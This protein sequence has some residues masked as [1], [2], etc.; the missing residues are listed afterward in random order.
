ML[1]S[2]KDNQYKGVPWQKAVSK[3]VPDSQKD[4]LLKYEGKAKETLLG[5]SGISLK[6]LWEKNIDSQKFILFPPKNSKSELQ[7]DDCIFSLVNETSEAPSFRTGNIMGF[8]HL[9]D[10]QMHITSRFD[11]GP[12]NFF[13]HY[14]LQKIGNVAFTPKTNSYE[15]NILDFLCYLF[16]NYLNNALKQ[17][18]FRAYVTK[19]YNDANVRGPIDVNRHIRFNTPFN[20]KIAYRTRE[21]T[22]DNHITQLIRH[23][24]EYIRALSFGK[25]ILGGDLP[26]ETRNNVRAI[27]QA[28]ETYVKNARRQVISKNLR[29][30]THPYYT[31]YEELRKLCLA[32]LLHKRLSYG[33]SPD[34]PISGILF[35]GASLWEEYLAKII[36]KTKLGIIHSNNRKKENGICLFKNGGVYYPDFYR[37]N[38]GDK[39]DGV[40]LDAKYKALAVLS[41]AGPAETFE[42]DSSGFKPNIDRSDLFQMLAYIHCIPVSKA[43]LLFPI[44]DEKNRLNSVTVSKPKVA[45]GQG[46]EISAIGFPIPQNIDKFD[47]FSQKMEEIESNLEKILAQ[48]V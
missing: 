24:I 39:P 10:I 23:T 9:D 4:E 46:G 20:G 26:R 31:M 42:S 13:L 19:E 14:M 38:S 12:N 16:P 15:D 27:E 29:P 48:L 35:D 32:I 8:F 22:T 33:N 47:V 3:G 6:D 34:N 1:I 45:R 5:F 18:I 44:K 7:N 37:R 17:G 36:A 28:T 2:L 21:Y 43:F 25:N 30:V 11:D 41:G 40:V